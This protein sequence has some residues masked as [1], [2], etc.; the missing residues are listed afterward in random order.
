MEKKKIK[1][2]VCVIA[3][4]TLAASVFTACGNKSATN[5][6]GA[7]DSGSSAADTATQA[8]ASESTATV[9]GVDDSQVQTHVEVK[10]EFKAEGDNIT[11][12]ENGGV[13]VALEDLDEDAQKEYDTDDLGFVDTQT[14]GFITIGMSRA[15]IEAIIGAPVSNQVDSSFYDG[16]GVQYKDDV[17]CTIAISTG[18]I[19]EGMN[20]QRFVTSRGVGLGTSIDDFKK[21]YGDETGTVLSETTTT[22]LTSRIF[23]R[24]GDNF[25]YIGTEPGDATTDLYSQEFMLDSETNTVIGI[26]I[27]ERL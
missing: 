1:K 17:A 21:A 18:Q 24:D 22:T 9:G 7:V 12:N 15:D 3:S 19:T 10:D 2:I 4:A 11:Q 14:G 16:I 27:R 20:A 25:T 6:T 8:P 26:S 5:P 23:Q 13:S